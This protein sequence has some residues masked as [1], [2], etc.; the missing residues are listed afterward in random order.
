VNE[1]TLAPL[2]VIVDC[3]FT[4]VSRLLALHYIPLSVFVFFNI[5]QKYTFIQN[6]F[7]NILVE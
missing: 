2:E 3:H 6:L 4:E 1:H 7:I 5:F